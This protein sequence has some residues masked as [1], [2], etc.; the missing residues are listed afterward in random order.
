MGWRILVVEDDESTQ[1]FYRHFF[2]VMHRP[3]FEWTLAGSAERALELARETKFHAVVLDWSLPRMS[4]CDLLEALKSDPKTKAVPVYV[5]TSHR[6][7]ETRE[8]ALGAG[9]RDFMT[10]PVRPET[11]RACLPGAPA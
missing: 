8:Q 4:G 2:E 10:K 1:E 5:V 6:A 9:A 11:L 7:V 3:D